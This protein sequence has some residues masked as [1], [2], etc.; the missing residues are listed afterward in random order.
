[1][2]SEQQ[3]EREALSLEE[4]SVH[5]VYEIIA[6]HFSET[7]YKVLLILTKLTIKSPGR[8]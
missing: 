1:M 8:W 6:S 2:I 5:R 4:D 3:D 7:R